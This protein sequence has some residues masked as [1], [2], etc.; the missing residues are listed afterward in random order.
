MKIIFSGDA[1]PAINIQSVLIALARLSLKWGGFAPPLFLK[2][3][4]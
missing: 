2:E 3:T 4:P 1:L